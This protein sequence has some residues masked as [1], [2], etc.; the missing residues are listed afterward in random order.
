MNTWSVSQWASAAAAARTSCF[1]RE[2]NKTGFRKQY[3]T[4]YPVVNYFSG[5]SYI[6][7]FPVLI[8]LFFSLWEAVL[9]VEKSEIFLLQLT[10]Q[11]VSWVL[12]GSYNLLNWNKSVTASSEQNWK[13]G[14]LTESN[15]VCFSSVVVFL[16]V[17]LFSCGSQKK[18]KRNDVW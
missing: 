5:F 9:C 6:G 2:F 10:W 14:H 12:Y 18:E 1:S 7:Y 4:I 15:S 13:C 16:F 11:F 17:L 3:K 8:R